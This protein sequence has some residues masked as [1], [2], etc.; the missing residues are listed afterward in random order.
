[1]KINE[2]M[3]LINKYYTGTDKKLTVSAGKPSSNG[4]GRRVGF[5]ADS[6]GFRVDEYTEPGSSWYSFHSC[7]FYKESGAVYYFLNRPV[8]K[9]ELLKHSFPEYEILFRTNE[10]GLKIPYGVV[11]NLDGAWNVYAG[12]GTLFYI[13]DYSLKTVREA[14]DYFDEFVDTN[15]TVKIIVN[16]FVRD[17]S[18][19]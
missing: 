12:D 16:R 13:N 19:I 14:A 7:A 8:Y 6:D 18:Q 15:A 2:L 11:M 3:N 9:E 10:R 5:Y 1:M 17:N 4:E